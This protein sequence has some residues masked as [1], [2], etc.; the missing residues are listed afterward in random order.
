M[1]HEKNNKTGEKMKKKSRLSPKPTALVTGAASSLG[2]AIS[3]K[4]AAQGF[5]IALHYGKSKSKTLE[6][7][8]ELE[9]KSVEILLVQANLAN[10]SQS[11]RLIQQIVNGWGRL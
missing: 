2:S 7:K 5:N 8:R 3:R 9:T 6:L 4:L 1:K 11:D 10:P